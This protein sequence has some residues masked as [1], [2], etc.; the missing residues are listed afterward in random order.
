MLCGHTITNS[1]IL[2]GPLAISLWKPV[3]SQ[4]FMPARGDDVP[5]LPAGI[6]HLS[7]LGFLFLGFVIIQNRKNH[8]NNNYFGKYG[9]SICLSRCLHRKIF[10]Q[11]VSSFVRNSTPFSF[12]CSLPSYRSAS[13]VTR[14]ALPVLSPCPAL[15]STIG[16]PDDLYFFMPQSCSMRTSFFRARSLKSV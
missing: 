12:L 14:T 11:I 5:A 15:P 3:C 13:F 16:L 9:F 1:P 4:T 10:T 6:T 2:L 7:M 8:P